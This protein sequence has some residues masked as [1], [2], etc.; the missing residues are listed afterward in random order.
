MPQILFATQSYTSRSI[1][2]SAQQVSNAFLEKQPEGAKSQVPVFGAPGLTTWSQVSDVDVRGF[3]N[4]NGV[5]FAVIGTSLYSFDFTGVAT[6]IG[7]GITGTGNVSM[8][9]NGIE[10]VIVN[11]FG[12]WDYNPNRTNIF[13]DLRFQ[14]IFNLNFYPANT[15]IFFDGYFVFDRVGTN[16]FFLSALYDGMTYSGLDFATAEA[17]PG[18]LVAVAQNL[19][20]LFLFCQNHIE[21]WYDAGT[22]SFPFQR[23]AGGVIEKG[24][25]SPLTV[26]AQDEALFFLG[27]DLVFY[28]L[29][30]N[31]PVRVSQHGVEHAFATYGGVSDA[32]CMT[33]TLEGH[34]MIHV[35]FPSVPHSWVY[36]ISTQ[37]WHERYS[38]DSFNADLMRWRGN[39]A[40]QIYTRILVGDFLTGKIFI[41]DW[42]NYTEDGNTMQMLVCS[43][44]L[45]QDRRRIF[46]PRLEI[47][48]ETGVGT[49]SGQGSTPQAMLQW[50]K[51]GGKTWSVLQPWRSMGKIG[52]FTKRLRWLS[53]GQAYQWTF[54]LVISDPVK[55]VLI[56]AYADIELGMQ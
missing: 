14:Q 32:V 46:I 28:R 3:W 34:K 38:R 13:P 50:S 40:I 37:F 19:Q 4:F 30:G 52:E 18:F 10:L 11:G 1:P 41:L 36:D 26:I 47:D 12:G 5:L 21:M 29:Q 51:D 55:R 24:C 20:L 43:S 27:Q 42:N 6:F 56:G 16:E 22:P 53:L 39:C 33:Y 31:V 48:M 23:Y 17:Q 7:S 44:T 49:A 15:V 9:D 35:T 25:V 45:A 2:L 54:R 8:A